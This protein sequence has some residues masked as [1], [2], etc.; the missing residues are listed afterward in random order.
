MH[1]F[2][3]VRI[4]L[5]NFLASSSSAFL[6]SVLAQLRLVNDMAERDGLF[7]TWTMLALCW[8]SGGG[9]LGLIQDIVTDDAGAGFL[10]GCFGGHDTTKDMRRTFAALKRH[11]DHGWICFA[12]TT[13][14][15]DLGHSHA[16]HVSGPFKMSISQ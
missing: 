5:C 9:P 15:P 8:Q 10:N 16:I 6:D 3:C 12:L 7:E 4:P 1:L 11:Q 2:A 14:A 13:S